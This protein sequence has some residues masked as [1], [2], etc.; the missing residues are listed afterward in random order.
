MLQ[1]LADIS[2]AEAWIV[3]APLFGEESYEQELRA[4]TTQLG[5]DNRVRFFGHRNDVPELLAACDIVAHTST[6]PEPFGKVI[7]EGM[8]SGRPVIATAAGGAV[9]IIRDG[10]DGLLVPPGN[11]EAL[12]A[13][14]RRL[15]ADP[16]LRRKLAEGGRARSRAFRAVT[17]VDA[18]R[19]VLS[20]VISNT[21]TSTRTGRTPASSSRSRRE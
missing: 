19:S 18:Y 4:L 12:T 3:G 11:V 14:L 8:A 17:M 2:G 9:E 6:A 15:V 16:Q 21:P 20:D 13:T 5:L 1:A 10:I 7:I